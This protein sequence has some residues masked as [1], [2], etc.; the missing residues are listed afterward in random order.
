M[1]LPASVPRRSRGAALVLMTVVFAACADPP[2]LS[3]AVNEGDV[4]SAGEGSCA[5]IVTVRGERYVGR[6]VLVEPPLGEG[7]G[8]AVIPACNDSN[9][10][11]LPHAWGGHVGYVDGGVVVGGHWL[12]PRFSK[13][14]YG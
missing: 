6:Q 12:V 7:S 14:W 9:G 10:G 3:R 13:Y 1:L 5:L 11:E 2:E 4:L 8:E